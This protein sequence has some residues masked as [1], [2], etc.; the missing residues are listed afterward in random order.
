MFIS[1]NDCRCVVCGEEMPEGYGMVCRNCEL[2]YH[3][4]TERH[5]Y[6]DIE[7][8]LM[9]LK[10]ERSNHVK[11]RKKLEKAEHDRDRYAKRIRFLDGRHTVLCREYHA[12]RKETEILRTAVTLLERR[13]LENDRPEKP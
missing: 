9:L 12:A 2:Q 6:A 10:T 5:F 11:T 8:L 7:K 4:R 1:K 3:I 13:L